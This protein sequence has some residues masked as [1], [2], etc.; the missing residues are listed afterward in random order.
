MLFGCLFSKEFEGLI[1]RTEG[2]VYC[3][4]SSK[5]S[6]ALEDYVTGSIAH[7]NFNL[8]F[9]SWNNAMEQKAYTNDIVIICFVG[10]F[11]SW[12]VFFFA[13]AGCKII[14]STTV[15]VFLSKRKH[16]AR[17]NKAY[18]WNEA[19]VMLQLYRIICAVMSYNVNVFY[20]LVNL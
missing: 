5:G 18:Y 8:L 12:F 2:S 13:L 17:L 7:Q 10:F 6:G 3:R 14:C 9:W 11:C 4:S 20:S 19:V 15:R 1:W 16:T